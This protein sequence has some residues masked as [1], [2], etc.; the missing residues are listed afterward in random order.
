M[1]DRG[2]I[3]R[4]V[5]FHSGGF[6]LGLKHATESDHLTAVAT[7]A[8]KQW[9][10]SQIVRQGIAWG[11]GHSLMLLGIGCL[12]LALGQAIPPWFAQALECTVGAML[13]VLGADV[14]RRVLMTRR[15]YIPV[16]VDEPRSA[17]A[18]RPLVVGMVH[19][20]AGSAALIVLSLGAMRSR[21]QALVYIVTF[22]IGSIAGMAALSAAMAGPLR[23]SAKWLGEGHKLVMAAIG[24]FSC[25]L[26]TVIVY[27]IAIAG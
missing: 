13:I 23:L 12:V 24:A 9:S 25:I 16:S 22:G 18:L 27:R 6:A 17:L 5:G 11:L 8:T 7:L 1:P 21:G 2:A 14:L 10:L 4:K 15:I 26:G 19:G 3:A 20:M